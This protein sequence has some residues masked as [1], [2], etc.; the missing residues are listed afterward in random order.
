VGRLTADYVHIVR[1][2]D[3]SV[4]LARHQS[5]RLR[6]YIE[7]KIE[8]WMDLELNRVKT[9]VVDLR[10]PW[11]TLD[12]ISFT[13]RYDRSLKGGSRFHLNIILSKKAMQAEREALC[14][15]INRGKSHVPIPKLIEEVNLQHCGA[16]PDTFGLV[17]EKL[18]Y[19]VER[20]RTELDEGKVEEVI[21]A[22][23]QIY[24][25]C[26]GATKRYAYERWAILRKTSIECDMLSSEGGGFLSDQEFWKQD[27]APSLG[28]G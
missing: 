1:Y 27:V 19:W 2:A 26:R 15:L 16:G 8:S 6:N 28:R 23:G 24:H 5:S 3:D 9:K 11:Q 18:H 7:S 13:F 25:R 14:A 10:R 21:R 22:I 4:V 20:R 17:K 12:F